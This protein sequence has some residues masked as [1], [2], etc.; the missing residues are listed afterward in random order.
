VLENLFKHLKPDFSNLVGQDCDLSCQVK[1]LKCFQDYHHV[2]D[3]EMVLRTSGVLI[4]ELPRVSVAT[5]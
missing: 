3:T 5:V 2:I 1:V 4:M